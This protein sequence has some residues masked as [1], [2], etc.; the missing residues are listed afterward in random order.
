MHAHCTH[1]LQAW[2]AAPERAAGDWSMALPAS[3]ERELGPLAQTL[4]PFLA[5]PDRQHLEWRLA[6]SRRDT[7]ER[8]IGHHELPVRLATRRQGRPYTLVLDKSRALF[9][10]ATAERRQWALDL[11][12]LQQQAGRFASPSR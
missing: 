5:A 9:E 12:W 2:R 10:Q 8:F 11:A 4:A 3:A 7:I 1:A 6:Q